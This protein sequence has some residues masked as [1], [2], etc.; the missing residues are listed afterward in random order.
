MEQTDGQTD[1]RL[2]LYVYRIWYAGSSSGAIR[3]LYLYLYRYMRPAA[4]VIKYKVMPVCLFT[5]IAQ[6]P[7]W[8]TSP[9]FQH[10]AYARGLVLLSRRYGT[11][12]TSGFAYDV[13]FSHNGTHAD[14]ARQFRFAMNVPD[15]VGFS[16]TI[17][18][19]RLRQAGVHDQQRHAP[20]IARP[21]PRRDAAGRRR[22]VGRRRRRRHGAPPPVVVGIVVVGVGSEKGWRRARV[23]AEQGVSGRHASWV[24]QP[25]RQ[26]PVDQLVA[27]RRPTTHSLYSRHHTVR[28]YSKLQWFDFLWI[29]C[30]TCCRFVVHQS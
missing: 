19:G 29:C 8:Q 6:K 20:V 7:R 30:T 26:V 9:F 24:A 23:V 2:M 22:G 12:S 17:D 1:I 27:V 5:R 21:A 10:V 25:H 18:R 14:L 16:S 4:V 11:L 13:M 15:G 28:L 3:F